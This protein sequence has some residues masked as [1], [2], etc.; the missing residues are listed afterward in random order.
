MK[1]VFLKLTSEHIE[2]VTECLDKTYTDIGNIRSYLITA[3]Y[4]SIQTVEN[5]TI[6]KVNHGMHEYATRNRELGGVNGEDD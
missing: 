6:Q 3:L 5:F 1:S 4:R 2:Y